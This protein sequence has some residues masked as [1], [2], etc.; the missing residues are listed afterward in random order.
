MKSLITSGI[1]AVSLTLSA[2]TAMAGP[3]QANPIPNAA[4]SYR[5]VRA[6]PFAPGYGA[7]RV[8]AR[9]YLPNNQL[10]MDVGQFI[11]G[12]L[13]GSLPPQ[14]AQI[15]RNAVRVSASHGSSGSYRILG[16]VR[17]LV[18][19]ARSRRRQQSVTG[20]HRR[21]GPGHPADGPVPSRHGCQQCCGTSA[22]RRRKRCSSTNR[23]QRRHVKAA[24]ECT[25]RAAASTAASA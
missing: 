20:G 11:S 13:G 25:T 4:Q 7:S 22:K 8:A 9:V 18:V 10:G 16:L 17:L 23:H 1:L 6:T 15:V 19:L 2:N 3:T 12:M 14:Y 21:L 24:R 5:T